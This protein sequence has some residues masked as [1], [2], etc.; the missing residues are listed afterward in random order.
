MQK[1]TRERRRTKF[2]TKQRSSQQN[3][4]SSYSYSYVPQAMIGETAQLQHLHV[5]SVLEG[6]R[7]HI[8]SVTAPS[9]VEVHDQTVLSQGLREA[10][11]LHQRWQNQIRHRVILNTQKTR[12]KKI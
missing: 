8:Q 1:R 6:A 5:V 4:C 9:N 10:T 7:A 11:G 2:A 12:G 3:S